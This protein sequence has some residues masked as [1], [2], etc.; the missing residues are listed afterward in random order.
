[1]VK[2]VIIHTPVLQGLKITV[3]PSPGIVAD[4]VNVHFS[5]C[6]GKERGSRQPRES[7]TH[8]GDGVGWGTVGHGLPWR[9]EV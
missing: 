1:L 9:R 3:E 8:D 5:T 4:V 2:E 6:S 7:S